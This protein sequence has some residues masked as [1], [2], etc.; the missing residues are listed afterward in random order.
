MFYITPDMFSEKNKQ[1][2]LINLDNVLSIRRSKIYH[3]LTGENYE[4]AIYFTYKEMTADF[5]EYATA[6]QRD[7]VFEEIMKMVES[8]TK[9]KLPVIIN[10]KPYRS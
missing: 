9:D 10:C 3:G 5:W 1:D 4:N 7:K 6:F 8:I 2:C